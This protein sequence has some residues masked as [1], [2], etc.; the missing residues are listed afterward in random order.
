MSDNKIW[1]IN[2]YLTAETASIALNLE[3]F[4]DYP[5]LGFETG[6]DMVGVEG[7]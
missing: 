5:N 2:F 3:S 4:F 6:D 1:S 7:M